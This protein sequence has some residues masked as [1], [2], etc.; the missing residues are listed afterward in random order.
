MSSL[1]DLNNIKEDCRYCRGTGL[2]MYPKDNVG[3]ICSC[4]RG[5][6]YLMLDSTNIVSVTRKPDLLFGD[7]YRLRT[8]HNMIRT[9]YIYKGIVL[10]KGI[11]YV[12][13]AND[14]LLGTV[15][16]SYEGLG[17]D[18]NFI[19]YNEYLAGKF[20]LPDEK[21]LCPNNFYDYPFDSDKECSLVCNSEQRSKC[22]HE[23]YG[24]CNSILEK[25]EHI[26]KH[27][28][29]LKPRKMF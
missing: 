29:S 28:K 5:L 12:A 26:A 20:P 11:K 3:I 27:I 7:V 6:G 21:V 1:L 14:G 18:G 2:I 10:V 13:F 19:S 23:F 4:C 22:W 25:Q 15:K 8:I 16:G 9:I 24:E 17:L